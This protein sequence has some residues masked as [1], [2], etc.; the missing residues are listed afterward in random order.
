M[1][2]RDAFLLWNEISH[3]VN[4]ALGL[5]MLADYNCASVIIDDEER[6]TAAGA[7]STAAVILLRRADALLMD[8]EGH[9][10]TDPVAMETRP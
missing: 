8:L 3:L 9:L 7:T 5:S 6:Q 2:N 10:K 1:H 4:T